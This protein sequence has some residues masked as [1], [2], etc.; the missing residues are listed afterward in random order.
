[1]GISAAI[2][3]PVTLLT[4]P[5]DVD[6]LLKFVGQVR[7]GRLGWSR[8]L[9]DGDPNFAQEMEP[10]FARAMTRWAVGIVLLFSLCFAIGKALLGQGT[11][12]AALFCIALISLT[13]LLRAFRSDANQ[14]PE[15]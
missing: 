1:V 6:L 15:G 7:P 9:K 3:L 11:Q 8:I 4:T 12:S 13:W 5:V 10:F 14:S 2:W